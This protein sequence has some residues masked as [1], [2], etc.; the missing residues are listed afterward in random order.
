MFRGAR[1]DQ[2]VALQ[3]G[4]VRVFAESIA[5]NEGHDHFAPSGVDARPR[6]V[7][8]IKLAGDGAPVCINRRHH[9]R[10]GVRGIGGTSAQINNPPTAEA[11]HRSGGVP[12]R[13]HT[14]RRAVCTCRAER[15]RK[16]AN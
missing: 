3:C 12:R 2:R 11:F 5:G 10:L 14:R 4:R 16:E 1:A 13:V 7:R 6:D 9:K 8:T 15:D